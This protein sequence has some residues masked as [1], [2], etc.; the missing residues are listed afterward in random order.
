MVPPVV[1][2]GIQVAAARQAEAAAS[3]VGVSIETVDEPR[4]LSAVA[5]M[6]ADI[7]ASDPGRPPIGADVLRAV[8]HAGGAVH[9][10]RVGPRPVGAAVAV[11]GS[12]D[13]RGA[14]SLIAGVR[15]T[16][17][18]VGF[19]LKCSQRAW[20][21]DHELVS[22][23]WTF[24]PLVSRNARFNLVKLGAVAVAYDV[25]FYGPL[26]DGLN[27]GDESDR[28]T[29]VWSLASAR[30]IDATCGRYTIV[31]GPDHHAAAAG[32]L[33]APDGQPLAVAEPGVRWCRVPTDIVAIRR[34]DAAAA[35][36]WRV[37]VREVLKAAFADG[38]VAT[39]MSRSGWY[40]LTCP[41][42]S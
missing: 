3:A 2:T 7:W 39:G 14:Y 42:S 26:D 30:T 17:R 32:D 9:L 13:S 22:L 21:L 5:A 23:T 27:V 12:P 28:L 36:R 34:G 37:A 4:R 33:P 19:A 8:A 1:T 25:D 40:R 11:F 38:F 31:N 35:G 10:A 16:D 6:L 20:A 24:D 29:V 15:T 18:G 41:E